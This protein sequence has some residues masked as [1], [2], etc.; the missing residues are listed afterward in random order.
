MLQKMVS[1]KNKAKA[2][3]GVDVK[4]KTRLKIRY[5]T[6]T[7]APDKLTNAKTLEI[8]LCKPNVLGA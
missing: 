6:D 2:C 1:V 4:D 5:C 8:V 3:K 7:K